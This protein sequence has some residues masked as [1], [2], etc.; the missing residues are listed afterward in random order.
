MPRGQI[1][2]TLIGA[3]FIW[4]A[5]PVFAESCTPESLEIRDNGVQAR[6]DIELAI[7][8]SEQQK[9]L[10]YRESMPQFAGMLF[11][12]EWPHSV[13]FWMKNT[14]LPLDMLFIDARGVVQRLH[15]NAEPLSTTPIPGGSGIQYVLEING[16]VSAMLGF[17]EGA[18]IRYSGISQENAAWPC[19]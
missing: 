2:A 14:L 6:F 19:E 10:M 3:C 8:P 11:I 18:E 16:G 4:L 9:G 1:L 15:E 13:S 12:Y 17:G 5:S 7:S